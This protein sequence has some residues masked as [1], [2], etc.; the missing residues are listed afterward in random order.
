MHFIQ[1]PRQYCNRFIASVVGSMK[2]YVHVCR[3]VLE[4]SLNNTDLL[5]LRRSILSHIRSVGSKNLYTV[6]DKY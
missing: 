1:K 6:E 2:L 3:K 4:F 5:K